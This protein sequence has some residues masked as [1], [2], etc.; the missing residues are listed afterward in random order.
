MGSGSVILLD[1][2]ALLWLDGGHGELGLAARRAAD[3]AFRRGRLAVSAIS[4]WE[5][6]RLLQRQRVTVRLPAEAWRRELIGSGLY[7][8]EIDGRVGILAAQ[9]E[10]LHRDPADRFIV[11]SAIALGAQLMTADQRILAWRGELLRL[12][13]RE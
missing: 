12:D 4:F 9:L 8:V 7:E 3:E 11:A 1:T 13:A 10:H 5:I 6:A 2:H